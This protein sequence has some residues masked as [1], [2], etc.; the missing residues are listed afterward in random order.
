MNHPPREVHQLGW[1]KPVS[2]AVCYRLETWSGAS[3]SLETQPKHPGMLRMNSFHSSTSER[4]HYAKHTCPV[5]ANNLRL[6]RPSGDSRENNLHY[7]NLLQLSETALR[8]RTFAS[9]SV[10]N[11]YGRLS[12]RC[13]RAENRVGP[14]SLLDCCTMSS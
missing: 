11:S 2:S 10:Q 9:L 8:D 12:W 5:F 4:S 3:Q 7:L 6:A 13:C 1:R 14:V